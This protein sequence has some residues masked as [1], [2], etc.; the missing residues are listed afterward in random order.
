[1]YESTFFKMSTS[2]AF[3]GMIAN[4][5]A[6]MT[7]I[8]H[9]N[10]HS[11]NTSFELKLFV[12]SLLILGIIIGFISV[13]LANNSLFP[14]VYHNVADAITKNG[15]KWSTASIESISNLILFFLNAIYLSS[16]YCCFNSLS[17]YKYRIS[18]ISMLVLTISLIIIEISNTSPRIVSASDNKNIKKCACRNTSSYRT[19]INT[20]IYS[21]QSSL[22]FLYLIN[23]FTKSNII[24][25]N[26]P[27]IRYRLI[28]GG[29]L[30]ISH[31]INAIFISIIE[32]SYPF[33][34]IFQ[35]LFT[36]SFFNICC[37]DNNNLRVSLYQSQKQHIQSVNPINT[38]YNIANIN[39]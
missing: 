14:S 30:F 11:K 38:V 18:L 21:I 33:T 22:D 1:M 39:L 5:L 10:N 8:V 23:I 29:L 20:A 37:R 15:C 19:G 3:T 13:F 32:I 28:S 36:L 17:K 7:I 9:F 24:S 12:I 2:V 31:L 25:I 27:L 4:L 35:S 34:I 16:H 6:L 26:R